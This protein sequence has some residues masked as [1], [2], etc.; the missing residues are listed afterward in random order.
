MPEDFDV[1]LPKRVVMDRQPEE[2][3]QVEEGEEEETVRQGL[4][5]GFRDVVDF[6]GCEHFEERKMAG[7]SNARKRKRDDNN[8][9]PPSP[10]KKVHTERSVTAPADRRT[11]GT[12]D[13]TVVTASTVH[14]HVADSA[15]TS[16]STLYQVEKK[17][18]R[19]TR[20]ATKAAMTACR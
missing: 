6:R 2:E 16:R 8:A 17:P 13:K 19:Q 18:V 12:E 5:E 1:S 15:D 4:W 20:V 14:I 11:V 9:T 10:S 3:E 7:M